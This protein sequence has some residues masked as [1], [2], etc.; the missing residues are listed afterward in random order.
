MNDPKKIITISK[1]ASNEHYLKRRLKLAEWMLNNTNGEKSL[2][3][4]FSGT[5][6]VR[7]ADNYYPFRSS[8][9][10]FYL[11]GFP[12]PNAWLMV[13]CSEENNFS[14]TIFC[15][16]KDPIQE[17][18]NGSRVG[19][20]EVISKFLFQNS[21][22]VESLKIE[23]QK[24]FC[25][26]QN[27]FFPFS[28]SIEMDK[29][30]KDYFFELKKH[31][32]GK[33]T[34]PQKIIDASQTI[35]NFRLI[36]D[37]KEISS[38]RK[39]AQI[40]SNA[41]I[42]AMKFCK[43]GIAEYELEAEIL[44]EFGKSGSQSVAYPSI[45]ASGP[46][47]CILH[48]KAGHRV[49]KKDEMILIDAGCEFDGYASDITR[50][51][52]VSGFFSSAQ[53]EIYEIVLGAQKAAIAA[54]KTGADFSDPHN[55]AVRVISQGIIDTGLLKNKSLDE[56]IDKELFKQ[57]YMHRTGHWLGMDVHDVGDYTKPLEPGMV[58]TI[59][60]GCYIR[61]SNDT[62]EHF[63]NIGIRIEDDA[64]VTKTGCELLTRKTPVEVNEI[65]S[66]INR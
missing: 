45:V 59:E 4:F 28:E 41:H 12:E 20:K 37:K 8:S 21:H 57:F 25:S 18:W 23:I 35:A 32:R 66:L 47:S 9:D 56:V 50:S 38:M 24:E 2:A 46:N 42:R 60:P 64:L 62:D 54:T 16:P 63:W 17:L 36:K 53:R 1:S 58:L 44:H 11:T 31:A 3:L 19:P 48:H 5:E 40:S 43:P 14:D 33:K 13:T 34:P 15:L 7:N 30:V 65:E 51:F 22:S 10:F 27:L 55:A 26:A 29:L 61:P 52:P 39:A 6:K 49:L